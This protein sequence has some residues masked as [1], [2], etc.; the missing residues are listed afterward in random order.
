ML[1]GEN[2]HTTRTKQIKTAEQ[3]LTFLTASARVVCLIL[4]N[5]EFPLISFLLNL[6]QSFVN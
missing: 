6:L 2:L 3:H 5:K 4:R 1:C